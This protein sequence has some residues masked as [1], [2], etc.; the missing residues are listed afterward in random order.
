M[1][2]AQLRGPAPVRVVWDGQSHNRVPAAPDNAPTRA[3]TGLGVP[4]ANVAN[5]GWGWESGGGVG[6]LAPSAPTRRDPQARGNGQTILMMLGGQGDATNGSGENGQADAEECY[7]RAERYRDS[8]YAAGFDL[9]VGFTYP[10]IG[11]D[12][13]GTGRPSPSEQAAI[14]GHNALM[15]DNADDWAAVVDCRTP[16]LD[17]ATDP[18]YYQIDRTHLTVAG[19]QVLA[20]LIRP[21]L[22]DLID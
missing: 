5:S 21:V 18:T 12:V 11:P 22:L 3:M 13:L 10:A 19:A 16:P 9:V 2:R 15:L 6:G 7:A 1:T 4:W 8:A 17:D 14:D 20:D